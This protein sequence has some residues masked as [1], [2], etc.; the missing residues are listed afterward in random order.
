MQ[1]V[2]GSPQIVHQP[3]VVVHTYTLRDRTRKIC[4]PSRPTRGLQG[5]LVF[6]GGGMWER[7]EGCRD[8]SAAKRL[9]LLLLLLQRA[10]F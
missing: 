8:G 7:E 1:R 6:K 3:G 5:E 10:W 4:A 9:L 2:L